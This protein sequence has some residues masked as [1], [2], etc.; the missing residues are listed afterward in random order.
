MG[1]WVSQWVAAW[2]V[3]GCLRV[4]VGVGVTC[5]CHVWVWVWT[6]WVWVSLSLS[7]CLCVCPCMFVCGAVSVCVLFVSRNRR[8]GSH[9][10][11]PFLCFLSVSLSRSPSLSL[12]L[13]LALSRSLSLSLA[14]SR[15]LSLSLALSRSRSLSLFCLSDSHAW[16]WR[17]LFGRL[18][19]S[20]RLSSELGRPL[21]RRPRNPSSFTVNVSELLGTFFL[22]NC[23]CLYP[24]Q[25]PG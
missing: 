1:V 6:V 7:L 4:G 17:S 23:V 25:A 24:T 14:L 20:V 10:V 3:C 2:V 9:G 5:G 13:S 11:K 22:R 8:F 15:S 18:Q 16:A 21:R 19:H 12:S